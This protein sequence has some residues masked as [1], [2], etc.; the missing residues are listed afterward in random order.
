MYATLP[1]ASSLET[2]FCLPGLRYLNVAGSR[3][4]TLVGI[5]REQKYYYISEHPR[6]LSNDLRRFW[7]LS[8]LVTKTFSNVINV[9]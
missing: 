5:Y 9:L 8:D 1:P 3:D 2:M 6:M 7:I 4:E